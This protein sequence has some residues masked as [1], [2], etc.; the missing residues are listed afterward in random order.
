MPCTRRD[1]TLPLLTLLVCACAVLA[2]IASLAPAEA[3]AGCS[4]STKQP[5]DIGRKQARQ[6]VNCL[7][8]KERN[9]RG[10]GDLSSDH[11]L[12]DAA[13]KH[14][15]VMAR[16]NCFSHQCRGEKT[17]LGRLKSVNYIVDGLSRWSY[18][19]NIAHGRDGS[20]TPREIVD[21]W[22]NS[23]AH[24]SAILSGTFKE[25]GAGFKPRGDKGF[26]TVD[27]GLRRR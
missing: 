6:A 13:V 3:A 26:Y 23:S 24:R 17:L 9:Q 18:G 8:N 7:I 25:M 12:V 27:F 19:E 2:L 21:D 16:K 5:Q 10:R 22:M 15:A 14:S 4:Y 11:R 1:L 20:G